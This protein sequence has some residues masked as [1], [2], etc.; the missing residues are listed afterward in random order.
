MSVSYFLFH[1]Y[2]I[3]VVVEDC[4]IVLQN[5]IKNN[6]SNQNFFKEGSYIQRLLPFVDIDMSS[7]WTA[8]KATNVLF[9]LQVIRTLVSPSNPL[10]VTTPCQKKMQSTGILEK[11]CN[12]LL[13]NGIPADILTEVNKYLYLF[14]INRE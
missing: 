8:Q 14:L 7:E 13:T 4:L 3:G 1:F 11:L 2:L 12:I 6:T 10:Q 9:L 5:L